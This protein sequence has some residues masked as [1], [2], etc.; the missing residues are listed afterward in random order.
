MH[1]LVVEFV[2]FLDIAENHRLLA[3]DARWDV[4]LTGH[5]VHIALQA[6]TMSFI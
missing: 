1:V 2:D 5:V 6:H 3:A 4:L